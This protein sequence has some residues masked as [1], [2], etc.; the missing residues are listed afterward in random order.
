M[1]TLN[2]FNAGVA[3][4][5]LNLAKVQE[6]TANRQSQADNALAQSAKQIAIAHPQ[7]VVQ[8]SEASARVLE[9]VDKVHS[10]HRPLAPNFKGAIFNAQIALSGTNAGE[11]T[12]GTTTAATAQG[13]ADAPHKVK[14]NP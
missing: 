9:A 11:N 12:K 13:S 14:Q 6:A 8:L 4:R 7:G 10:H 2:V 5:D 3:Q 1:T